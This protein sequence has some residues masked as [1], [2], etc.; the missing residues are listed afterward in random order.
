MSRS[1]SA[2]VMTDL[3]HFWPKMTAEERLE[4]NKD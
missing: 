4:K 1:I 3:L 2:S